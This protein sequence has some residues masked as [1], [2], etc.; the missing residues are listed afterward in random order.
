VLLQRFVDRFWEEL[1]MALE[2]GPALERSQA[3]L[4]ALIEEVKRTYLRQISRAGVGVLIEE[5][6]QII[7]QGE[8]P[9]ESITPPPGV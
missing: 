7:V 4:C 3:L 6:D 8:R 1:A 2:S 9:P 5:L